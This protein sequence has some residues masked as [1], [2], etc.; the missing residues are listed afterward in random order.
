ME[1]AFQKYVKT[2]AYFFAKYGPVNNP[3]T[4][5]TFLITV[6]L[7]ETAC[8]FTDEGLHNTKSLISPKDG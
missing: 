1:K 2:I 6:G 5:T 4:R 7:S 8:F 3:S